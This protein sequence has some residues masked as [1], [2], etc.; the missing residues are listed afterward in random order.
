MTAGT[1][2]ARGSLSIATSG[3]KGK[4][5]GREE[6]APAWGNV[7]AL[8]HR[9]QL[10]FLREKACWQLEEQDMATVSPDCCPH[11]GPRQEA[12]YPRATPTVV[13][14]PCVKSKKPAWVWARLMTQ[15]IT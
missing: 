9:I 8:L 10:L 13:N 1:G 11:P 7:V 2:R 3:S 5:L 15:T 4:L 12:E 6:G 14:P